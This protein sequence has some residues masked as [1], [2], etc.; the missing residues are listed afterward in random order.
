MSEVVQMSCPSCCKVQPC[1][2]TREMCCSVCLA[3]FETPEQL[4][5]NLNAT[6]R[7]RGIPE[8][9][10]EPKPDPRDALLAQVR[11]ALASV[12]ER[13]VGD[14]SIERA[15][16]ELDEAAMAIDKYMGRKP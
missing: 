1:V 6:R 12:R 9:V 5:A 2:E 15:V 4:D 13:L 14:G 3:M 11:E 8:V 10:R 16:Y 7:A